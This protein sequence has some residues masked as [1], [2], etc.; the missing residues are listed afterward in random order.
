VYAKA[1]HQNRPADTSPVDVAVA[2]IGFRA[3][4]PEEVPLDLL[5]L[6][7]DLLR[8]RVDQLLMQ[9]HGPKHG[10]DKG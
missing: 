6:L 2:A 7:E 8:K 5:E 3:A 10:F 1:T 4:S 9:W